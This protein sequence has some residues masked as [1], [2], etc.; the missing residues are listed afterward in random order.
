MSG[1]TTP[2]GVTG[3]PML[4][5]TVEVGPTQ[6]TDRPQGTDTSPP[7]VTLDTSKGGSGAPPLDPPKLSPNEMDGSALMQRITEL[8]SKLSDLQQTRQKSEIDINK[9][10][11]KSK[12][13]ETMNKI[14]AE[15]DKMRADATWD[16]AK[17]VFSVAA[18]IFGCVAAIGLALFTGGASLLV[19]GAIVCAV[20]G[21]V[22]SVAQTTGLG[23]KFLVDVCK[24]KPQDAQTLMTGLVIGFAIAGILFTGGASLWGAAEKAAPMIMTSASKLIGNMLGKFAGAA[25]LATG[26]GAGVTQIGQSVAQGELSD[27]RSDRKQTESDYKRLQQQQEEMVDELRELL[28]KLDEGVKI[29]TQVVQSTHQS[30]QLQIRN[31]T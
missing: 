31:M 8:Q 4:D 13:L 30:T 21:T 6:T 18:A 28:K 17:K 2:R 29:T 7:P 10:S 9:D 25:A 22:V 5:G 23:E 16:T 20:A 26:A 11:L 1:I 3:T 14:G 19:A 12:N 27:I 15:F 24:M